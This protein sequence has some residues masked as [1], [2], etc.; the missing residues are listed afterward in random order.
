MR[1]SLALGSVIAV[2]L[3]TPV[4]SGAAA[5]SRCGSADWP[6]YGHDLTHTFS[7]P[8][9]C[10]AITKSNVATLLPS[11]YFHT[12]DS[13]TASPA[14]SHG[15]LYVGTWDGTF[16]ALDAATGALRWSY[17]IKTTT[18]SAFGR[19]VSSASVVTAGRGAERRRVVIFGGGSRVWA[20]DALTGRKL[21]SINLDPRT[22]ADRRAGQSDPRVVEVESSPAVTNARGGRRH[23]YV[24][25][26]V[27]DEPRVGR[28]GLVALT[29]VPGP[30]WRLQPR[31]K[32]DVETGRVYRGRAGLTRGSG[33]GLG[34]G[35][36]WSSPT[37]D[38][39]RH[40]VV[41]GT[42]SCD[43]PGAAYARHRN[44]S[45][46]LLAVRTTTGHRAWSY[47]PE[48]QLK[49]A[50]R[51]PAAENDADFGASPNIFR[52][53]GGRQVVGDGS[54]SARYYVRGL[55]SGRKV[56]TAYAGQ[57]GVLQSGFAVGGFIGSS[58]IERGPGG[59]AR[60]V[61]GGTAIPHSVHDI[62]K[63]T[64]DVRAMDPRTGKID[65]VYRLG[66]PT[67]GATS[68]VNGIAFVTL[69]VQSD[70]I[71]LDADT[72]RL[73]W[74]APV[75]GPPS[76]TAVVV[77]DSVYVATGTRETDLEYKA[78]NDQLQNGMKGLIGESPLSP[79]S[80]V[81]A[82]RLAADRAP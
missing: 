78:V 45:E 71:A 55:R 46:E 1:R 10:S 29:L 9:G 4:S 56:S 28:T 59:A 69:T 42:A 49:K 7:V 19:I 50:E 37:V 6:M 53:Q 20:L 35:G 34:C 5:H 47:R 72:G 48:D 52:V 15:I 24:G 74:T 76:S 75:V 36:I 17:R 21:A 39:S 63:S 58:G 30:R 25:M 60:R 67:Y 79:V 64:W 54:K 8:A 3:L 23:I 27:H 51:V 38:L 22:P 44:Y 2:F 81:Q 66:A 82:F 11:W 16:Y 12:K 68:V 26:D 80:G 40:L 73:L 77:G 41:V 33:H 32:Y 70:V 65:W 57:S 14:V 43:Y 13:V 18:P 61:I 31:W 62:N